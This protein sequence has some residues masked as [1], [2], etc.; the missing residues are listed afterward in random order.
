MDWRV[1]GITQ[2]TLSIIPGGFRINDL[3]Q[4]KL[5]E[6][7]NFE[8][9]VDRKVVNDWAVLLSHMDELRVS[10]QGLHYVEV[11]SGWFPTLPICYYLGG[12]GNCTTFDLVRHMNEEHTFRLVRDLKP[13][14]PLIAER[15]HRSSSDVQESYDQLLRCRTL[16]QLLR[17]AR[18]NYIAPGDASKTGLPPGSV[19]VVFS[20]S[21][22][23]HVPL[24]AIKVIMSEARRILKSNG[25]SIHSVNC[26]DHFAYFDSSISAINY[27]Q[28]SEA[29][30]RRWNTPFLYQN[31]LRPQDFLDIVNATGFKVLLKKYRAR[32]DL[33]QVLPHLRIAPEFAKYPP[34]Q[35][36]CTSIDFVATPDS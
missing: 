27:L 9:T 21:V 1:K 25:L 35:L 20:N 6:L 22:L 2:R 13:Y 23:E 5:G 19:D 32:P 24:Q 33:L 36:A 7:R 28:F 31:R 34:E 30:W 18:I 16:E 14:L 8:A 15:S 12:A 26:G 11:G 3:L 29:E 17:T 4:R 10:P